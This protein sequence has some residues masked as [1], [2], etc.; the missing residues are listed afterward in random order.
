MD[1]PVRNRLPKYA[2]PI[3]GP[4][5]SLITAEAVLTFSWTILLEI[6]CES[7]HGPFQDHHNL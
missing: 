2:W 3:P 6:V 1:D 4:S 7:M 5:T